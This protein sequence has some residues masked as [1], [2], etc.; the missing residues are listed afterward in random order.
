MD[1]MLYD[2]ADLFKVFGDST[3]LRILYQLMDGE[4]CVGDLAEALEM[5]QSAVSHQL[6]VLKQNKLVKNTRSGKTIF[7]ALADE[8]VKDILAIGKEHIE[9]L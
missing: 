1:E 9:E 7:Y 6:K 8:H 5:N 2:L 4:S 3:R